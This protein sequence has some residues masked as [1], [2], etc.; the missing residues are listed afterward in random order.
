ME[1]MTLI[2]NGFVV[3]AALVGFLAGKNLFRVE[4]EDLIAD[5]IVS[6]IDQGIIK[7][8][9]DD[10]GEYKIFRHDEEIT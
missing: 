8:T 1:T 4:A 9:K 5:T 2:Q 3:L 10:D 6:L 7:A